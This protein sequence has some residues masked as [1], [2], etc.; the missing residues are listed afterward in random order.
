[1]SL[2]YN[3]SLYAYV[4]AEHVKLYKVGKAESNDTFSSDPSSI[5]QTSPILFVQWQ[6]QAPAPRLI[7]WEN[8]GSVME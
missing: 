4:Q 6:Q 1:M 7:T 2:L 3:A 5:I 8:A